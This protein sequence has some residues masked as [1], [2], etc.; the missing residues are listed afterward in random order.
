MGDKHMQLLI[1]GL[2]LPAQ[3]VGI[4]IYSVVTFLLHGNQSVIQFLQPFRRFEDLYSLFPTDP[5]GNTFLPLS[6]G[7]DAD[8]FPGNDRQAVCEQ[9]VRLL[10]LGDGFH[11]VGQ[12]LF[13]HFQ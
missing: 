9:A 11:D 5:A 3:A 6:D 1:Q 4:G 8:C 13:L 2:V 7:S 10:Q 12:M